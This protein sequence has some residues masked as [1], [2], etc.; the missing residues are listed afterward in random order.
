MND[1]IEKIIDF[2]KSFY[3][4]DWK[5]YL[6]SDIIAGIT[7]ALI[8]IPQSMAY[9][10][11]AWLPLQVWLYTAFIWVL[12]WWFFGSSKQMSTG[13]VTIV[14]LMTATALY[15]LWIDSVEWYM[16]Y[17]SL[18]AFFI[19]IFYLLLVILRLWIIVEFISHPV[20][21]WFTNAIAIV[22]ITS[23]MSKIFWISINESLNYFQWIISMIVTAWRDTNIVTFWF[24]LFWIS[25]LIWLKRYWPR[26]P[27][28][29]ILLIISI[30]ASYLIWYEKNFGWK[31][32]WVISKWLPSFWIPFTSDLANINDYLTIILFA[33]IIWLIWFTE[34]IAVAKWVAARTKQ[35]VSTNKELFSQALANIWSGLFGW[36]WVAGSFSRTAVNLRAWA[37]T[38]LSSIITWVI[39]WITLIYLT[40]LLYHLP[41][42][43]LAAIII[44]AVASLIKIEP[45]IESWKIQKSDAY[46]A[47]ITFIWTI[48]FTPDVEKAIWIWVIISLWLYIY[49]SMKPKVVELAMYKNWVLRDADFFKLKKPKKVSVIR[50]DWNLFFANAWYFEEEALDIISEKKSLK[51]VI[52]DF[53]WMNDIDSSWF[54][55]LK[56][57]TEKLEKWWIKVYLSNL[58]VNVI[59][60]LHNVEYLEDFGK[61]RIY[62]T[63]EDVIEFLED[64]YDKH[65]INIKPLLKYSP[66]KFKKSD[67]IWNKEI[68]RKIHWK[69]EY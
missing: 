13:P 64:K 6:R 61:K 37:R 35:K 33:I 14:S 20:V 67:K 45:I 25:L 17:A 23:Q 39:V 38:W 55:I 60:K 16:L 3:Q 10:G 58:R 28:I 8:I 54:V 62:E 50:V 12:I 47:I 65:E 36:Y 56:D 30:V 29:L 1:K 21:V 44:V 7:V 42:A 18:L 41:T 43:V 59:K 19:W 32:V 31:V 2:V 48:I 66:K 51:I 52:F 22:T 24:W 40:P 26:I 27:R 46:V 34:S 53:E 5:S 4:I 49:K 11:L 15:S 57:F 9:A 68:F 63:V 69:D